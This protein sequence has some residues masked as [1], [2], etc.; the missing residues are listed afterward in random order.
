MNK[1][2]LIFGAS[3][4]LGNELLEIFVSNNNRVIATASS[5][6]SILKS[7]KKFKA[8]KI[9]W[10]L[11]DFRKEAQIIKVIDK[12]FNKKN[13]PDIIIICS[14]VSRYDGLKKI[15]LKNLIEDFKVNLFSNI[16]INKQVQKRKI[17]NKK[18][19]IINIGSSSSYN[20]FENTISYCASKHALLGAVK[21]INAECNKDKIFNSLVSMGSMKTNMGKKVKNQNFKFFIQ[22]KKIAKYIYEIAMNDV[23][24]YVEDIFFKRSKF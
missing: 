15:N 7:K 3:G 13:N 12:Y 8:T 6:R 16:L 24:A 14:A 18:V 4:G 21:S 2:V 17:K 23:E 22:P 20:G 10:N 1:Q 19:L 5:K 11:C 9:D